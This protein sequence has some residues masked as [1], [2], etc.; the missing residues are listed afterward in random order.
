MNPRNAGKKGF[1]RL[2]LRP[3]FVLLAG[4]GKTLFQPRIVIPAEAGIQCFQ[5]LLGSR[6]RGSDGSVEFFRIL[7]G[8]RTHDD[9]AGGE[10]RIRKN[11]MKS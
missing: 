8:K 1:H 6:F 10:K 7:L 11:L 2:Y 4:C 5:G 3:F 9:V